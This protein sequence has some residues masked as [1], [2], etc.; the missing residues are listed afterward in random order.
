MERMK[1]ASEAHHMTAVYPLNTS[2][3]SRFMPPLFAAG[4]GCFQVPLVSS[5]G[6]MLA[7]ESG[8]TER[9]R[10]EVEKRAVRGVFVSVCA[11]ARARV[12]S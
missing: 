3:N 4:N 9:C 10:D 8:E 7:E 6:C 12:R 5:A 2:G 1:A 11:R